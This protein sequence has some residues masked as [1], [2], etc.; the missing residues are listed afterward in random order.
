MDR[1]LHIL[2]FDKI[3]ERLITRAATNPG[4]ERAENL[5]PF[6][7]LEDVK[8][9]MS[10]TR[11]ASVAL[12]LKGHAP[13]GGI[14][15][16]RPS[17]ERARI[18]GM[19][20]PADLLDIAST[21]RAGA[22]L[23]R[24]ILAVDEK[25]PL[26][27]MRNLA[28]MIQ[29]LGALQ[30]AIN[31][32]IDEHGEVSDA[33][34]PALRAARQEIRTL[35]SRVRQKLESIIRSSSYQKML[36][37]QIITI[38]NNRYVVPVKPEYR[39]S[40]G[41]IV[42][43]QSASGATLF[44]EPE[45]VVEINNR[46]RE[47]EARETREIERILREL[48][49]L[50][51]GELDVLATNVEA[52]GDLDFIFAK[53]YDAESSKATEPKLNDKGFLRLKKARHPLLPLEE[54][55]PIDME[56][57]RD[58]TALVITG[59]NTG[60][61]TV[62]LKTIGLLT[63]MAMSGL[64]IPAEEDSETAVFSGVYADIGDE[65]SIE[66]NLSTFSGH[67]KNIVRILGEMDSNSLILFDELGAG[68]DPTEGAAL[69]MAV[70]DHVYQR[71]ARV[72]ATTHYSELKAFAFNRAGIMNASVEFDEETLRPTYRLLLGVPGR[73]N[74]FA[75]ASRLGLATEIIEAA[76]SHVGQEENQVDSMLASLEES[77]KKA[78]R[79]EQTAAALRAETEK[80]REELQREREQ[81]NREQ[82]TILRQAEER[83]QQ[84]ITAASKEAEEIIAE[85]RR[86]AREEQAGIKEHR[87][88]DAKK[89]LEEAVPLLQ[90]KNG[91][92]L[93]QSIAHAP[94]PVRPGDEVKV[95]SLGQKG[96]IVQDLG[97][98]KYQV[99]IGLIKTAVE[100]EDLELIEPPPA[101]QHIRVPGVRS[102]GRERVKLELDLRGYKVED[103]M[104]EIDKYLD[105]ALLAGLSRVSI[106]H[107]LGTGQLRKGVQ[108]YL[109]RHKSVSSFRFGVHGEGGLGVTIVDLK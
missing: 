107:G 48:S 2:E 76:K 67:M 53:A 100:A 46:L 99:Q 94:K 17:L 73:S 31:R 20:H 44:I 26:E 85:L 81:L 7:H 36:Q 51:A 37:E 54:A 92:R 19:L 86:M 60:G 65:Q 80:L 13:L 5:R 34:S 8:A 38:R 83:A 106:I 66:Q 29:P 50:V 16:I 62:S 14:R 4:K 47:A 27:I 49:G 41:G 109:R 33:A 35:E 22:N 24:F 78:E 82:E 56:L 25:E 23:K 70:I 6:Y 43:D 40:F 39:Q 103:A 32:A 77:R 84:A 105:D 52:L 42:H 87:L 11:E 79:E 96:H 61:K 30:E 57:G 104:V 28:E 58:F 93:K 74:A 9:A 21:L 91:R 89:R 10:E 1:V 59:P 71:G 68:T 98:G 3:I 108:E 69:A 90:G 55:V 101:Q 88:I 72:V 15:D 97:G 63:L 102:P 12:R 45:A 95:V 64:F 18:G 75:I